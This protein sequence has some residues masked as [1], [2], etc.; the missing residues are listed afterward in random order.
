MISAMQ[1]TRTESYNLMIKMVSTVK[2][3]ISGKN[4]DAIDKNQCFHCHYKPFFTAAEPNEKK[5]T[6]ARVR[7]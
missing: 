1:K 5:K 4:A 6:V 7:D 3:G 2:R